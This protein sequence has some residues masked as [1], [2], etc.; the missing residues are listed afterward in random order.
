MTKSKRCF[1]LFIDNC[2][3]Y[4]NLLTLKNIPVKFLRTN[5]TSKLQPLNLGIICN[6]KVG[7]Q[8]QLVRR[9]LDGIHEGKPSSNVDND[10]ESCSTLT[11]DCF[12]H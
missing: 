3:A 7:Y 8:A 2:K 5:K 11:V 9:L 1:V 4:S 10:I 6:V 12:Q